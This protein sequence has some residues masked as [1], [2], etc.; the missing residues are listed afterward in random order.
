MTKVEI[1]NQVA[2][3][4]GITQVAVKVVINEFIKS[5]KGSLLRGEKVTLREFGTFKYVQGAPRR[6][7]NVVEGG[8]VYVPARKKIKFVPGKEFK[9]SVW[10]NVPVK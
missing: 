10:K 8:W 7:R 4:T 6:A 2:E 3:K 9:K 5:V 1:A